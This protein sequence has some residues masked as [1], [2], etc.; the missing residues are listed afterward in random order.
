MTQPP[1]PHCTCAQVNTFLRGYGVTDSGG[2]SMSVAKCALTDFSAWDC[3]YDS[4]RLPSYVWSCTDAPPSAPSG[5]G[6]SALGGEGT[7]T[8]FDELFSRVEG[9]ALLIVGSILVAC[10]LCVMLIVVRICVTKQSTARHSQQVVTMHRQA[11]DT[12][13]P[14]S[15]KWVQFTIAALVS[16]GLIA[17]SRNMGVIKMPWIS[18]K[19]P[20]GTLAAGPYESII[21]ANGVAF[22]ICEEISVGWLSIDLS[23]LLGQICDPVKTFRKILHVSYA[24]CALAGFGMIMAVHGVCTCCS[25]DSAQKL[26]VGLLAAGVGLA[27][28]CGGY[29]YARVYR[30]VDEWVGM[31][32]VQ[33]LGFKVEAGQGFYL[34]CA[35]VGVGI[36]AFGTIDT[37][38]ARMRA[39]PSPVVLEL[40]STADA[41]ANPATESKV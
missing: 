9:N 41:V 5:P 16:G 30:Y 13:V 6:T 33:L 14:R 17:V 19:G 20:P 15:R 1:G 2:C 38:Q 8:D 35:G 4:T 21:A 39:R 10:L 25:I 23:P 28:L 12:S 29:W 31:P 34:L 26:M 32:L 11:L 7:V 18:V 27:V 36:L 22:P 37:S 3:S 40:S 24:L